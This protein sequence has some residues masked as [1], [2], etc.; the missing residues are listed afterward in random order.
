MQAD[1]IGHSG[2]VNLYAYVG[3]DPVNFVDPWG[4]WRLGDDDEEDPPVD[5]VIVVTYTLPEE[6]DCPIGVICI[7]GGDFNFGWTGGL[8]DFNELVPGLN[9]DGGASDEGAEE[10]DRLCGPNGEPPGYTTVPRAPGANPNLPNPYMRGPDGRLHLTPAWRQAVAADRESAQ[11]FAQPFAIG[12]WGL[13]AASGSVS[14]AN[15]S[16]AP[17]RL[18]KGVGR[19]AAVALP[20]TAGITAAANATRFAPPPPGGPSCSQDQ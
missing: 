12:G 11:A 3:G 15:Q 16:N 9:E 17:S 13:S 7:E 19:A 8:I 18:L 4:L 10:Q 14:M 5:D 6:D 1:P 2:G 20:V